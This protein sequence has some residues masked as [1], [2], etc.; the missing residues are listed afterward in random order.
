METTQ[1]F[2]KENEGKL[3]IKFRKENEADS[4]STYKIGF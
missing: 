2:R 3:H 4:A 1:K